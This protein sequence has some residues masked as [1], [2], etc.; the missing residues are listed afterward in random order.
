MLGLALLLASTP[1]ALRPTSAGARSACSR[2]AVSAGI[3]A[4]IA[5]PHASEA[6]FGDGCSECENKELAAE[7]S[8]L[9]QELK[10]RTEANK[11][12]NEATVKE[13]TRFTSGVADEDVKMVRYAGPDDTMPVTRMMTKSQIKE[14]ESL[15]FDVLCPD[16]GGACGI[17]P[18]AKSAPPPPPP[19]PP[20]DE[21]AAAA[22]P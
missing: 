3:L 8:P 10:R 9:I 15:G 19:P 1:A 13:T 17:K 20:A 2:R 18:K 7:E 11:E 5:W 14:L 22:A 4:A 16:W 12:R 21:P 6:K